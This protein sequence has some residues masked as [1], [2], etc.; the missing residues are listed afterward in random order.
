MRVS[1]IVPGNTKDISGGHIYNRKLA[2]YAEGIDIIYC[3]TVE[4]LLS[5]LKKDHECLLID[6]WALHDISLKDINQT[7]H[8]L[9]HHPIS[10]DKTIKGDEKKEV[11][12]WKN[13]R[14]IIT[15]SEY[16]KN[17]IE[18]FCKT[19]VYTITPGVDAVISKKDYPQLPKNITGFGSVIERKGDLLLIEA[20]KSVEG[21]TVNRFGP[22]TDNKYFEKVI[23][24]AG[25]LKSSRV[26][27]NKLL[28][29]DEKDVAI[30]NTELAVFPTFYE[31]YGMAIQECLNAKTPVLTSDTKGMK[32]RFGNRGI[33]YIQQDANS[34][35]KALK[36]YTQDATKYQELTEEIKGF[37]Y[38]FESWKKKSHELLVF[39]NIR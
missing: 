29:D 31:S 20:L 9:A 26:K 11:S 37:E 19:S 22:Q 4:K 33:R 23:K 10:L 8:L 24:A 21:L 16:V 5:E 7:F 13:A 15:T 27:F 25:K 32:A 39:L 14:S 35:T 30:L 12:F 38:D 6:A 17:Y 3:N 34:W 1:F 2:Q 28:S 18:G 36:T